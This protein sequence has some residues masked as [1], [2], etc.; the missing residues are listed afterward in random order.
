MILARIIFERFLAMGVCLPLLLLASLPLQAQFEDHE[1][2]ALIKVSQSL[3]TL[4]PIESTLIVG[5]G[6]SPAPVIADLQNSASNYAVNL[7]LSRFRFRLNS[8]PPPGTLKAH[9][10][11]YQALQP[12]EEAILFEHFDQFLPSK[13]AAAGR[14]LVFLDFSVRGDSLISVAEYVEKYLALRGRTEKVRLVALTTEASAATVLERARINKREI[15][16]LV[17]EPRTSLT[18]K[19][20]SQTFD[21]FAEFGEFDFRKMKDFGLSQYPRASLIHSTTG[22]SGYSQMRQTLRDFRGS[23]RQIFSSP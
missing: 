4:H 11:A 8:Q 18:E 23:C 3:Q 15:Q 13:E 21:A 20:I 7:P 6:R 10:I 14:D 9:Q 2:P 1:I 22:A 5:V 12:A 16:H 17:L 19:F